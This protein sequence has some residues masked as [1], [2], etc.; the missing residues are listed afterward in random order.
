MPLIQIGIGYMQ[1]TPEIQALIIQQDDRC[2][3]C[4]TPLGDCALCIYADTTPK[5]GK[6]RRLLCKLCAAQQSLKRGN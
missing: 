2:A 6:P 1:E 3:G 4:S 5:T